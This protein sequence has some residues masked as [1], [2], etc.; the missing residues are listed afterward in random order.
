MIYH[1]IEHLY[2]C[3]TFSHHHSQTN[4]KDRRAHLKTN[5]NS[6]LG[7][8]KACF[9]K[10]S[11]FYSQ[12]LITINNSMNEIAINSLPF[13]SE[14]RPNI[15][16]SCL[17]AVSDLYHLDKC[18][19]TGTRWPIIMDWQKNFNLELINYFSISGDS[20]KKKSPNKNWKF[21][22]NCF[23]TKGI[24]TFSGKSIISSLK[25]YY[26]LMRLGQKWV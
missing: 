19:V 8:S 21:D 7:K 12:I 14:L 15:R 3:L 24:H 5:L 10:Q 20:N 23:I 22:H 1:Q 26:L 11:F 4:T 6:F 18:L 16:L 9:D 2:N 13:F 25:W 17:P